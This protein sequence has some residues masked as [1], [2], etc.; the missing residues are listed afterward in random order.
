MNKKIFLSYSYNDRPWVEQFA[1]VLEQEGVDVWFDY[2]D[3][4][5]GEDIRDKIQEAL[6]KSSVLVVFLS[7]NSIRSP[8]IF[9]ELGAAVADNKK[10]IPIVIDEIEP[11]K[12]PLPLTKYQYLK[13]TSPETAA[14]EVAKA[15]SRNDKR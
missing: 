13:E 6:R 12:L 11:G 4:S 7:N 8:Y 10:I 9:F 14:K 15:L 2:H 1:A 5:L 3:I